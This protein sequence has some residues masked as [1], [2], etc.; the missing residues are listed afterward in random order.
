[1]THRKISVSTDNNV[2]VILYSRR[3]TRECAPYPFAIGVNTM[4]ENADFAV[5]E[6]IVK[7]G[8]EKLMYKYS[9]GSPPFM[10]SIS[11]ETAIISPKKTFKKNI[12]ALK[13]HLQWLKVDGGVSYLVAMVH[14][15]NEFKRFLPLIDIV[16]R[17]NADEGLKI[18]KYDYSKGMNK[19][20]YI[21]GFEETEFVQKIMKIM[22]SQGYTI[23]PPEGCDSA[24]E[25]QKGKIHL[26]MASFR[27]TPFLA[28]SAIAFT[29]IRRLKNFKDVNS[30]A[31]QMSVLNQLINEHLYSLM[32]GYDRGRTKLVKKGATSMLGEL[33]IPILSECRNYEV[34]AMIKV[35]GMNTA[36]TMKKK[37]KLILSAPEEA[38]IPTTAKVFVLSWNVAGWIPNT[39]EPLETLFEGLDRNNLPDIIIIGLQEVV[40]LKAKN[41][42]SFFAKG[43]SKVKSKR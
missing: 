31:F 34:D 43:D 8:S 12:M 38:R 26:T 24:F 7:S 15:S 41:I 3:S 17:D 39:I 18:W 29:L 11:R 22:L 1:M 9:S 21:K 37:M 23:I 32:A 30:E 14:P 25:S 19:K 13:A 10:Y 2:D 28:H 20:S 36:F 16:K 35:C 5:H 33:K 6:L 27:R 4:G 40:E 42:T